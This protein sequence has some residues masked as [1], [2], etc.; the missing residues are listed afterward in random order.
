MRGTPN[1]VSVT[2]STGNRLNPSLKTLL[3]SRTPSLTLGASPLSPIPVSPYPLPSSPLDSPPF[4][5][6]DLIPDHAHEETAVFGEAVRRDVAAQVEARRGDD[7][8]RFD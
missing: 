5:F 4:L 7:M 8:F 2:P 6:H 3:S 1:I